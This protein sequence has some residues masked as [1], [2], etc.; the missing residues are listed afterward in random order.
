MSIPLHE[1]F[2]RLRHSFSPEVK[3]VRERKNARNRTVVELIPARWSQSYVSACGCICAV[4]AVPRLFRL[5]TSYD[6]L[7]FETV[8]GILRL[9][10]YCSN[11]C[12]YG[13][14]EFDRYAVVRRSDYDV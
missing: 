12:R 11:L 13:E 6:M 7:S 4:E 5:W 2:R 9:E 10:G 8:R 14:D 3:G 1:S